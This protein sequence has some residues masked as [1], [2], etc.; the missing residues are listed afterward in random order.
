MKSLPEVRS[1]DGGVSVA[2]VQAISNVVSVLVIS[3]GPVALVSVDHQGAVV[4]V[5]GHTVT[6]GVGITSVA[7]RVSVGVV[8]VGIGDSWTVINVVLNPVSS[9]V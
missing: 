6:V 4:H 1:E 5:V 7:L 2:G 8:L 3:A 9:K